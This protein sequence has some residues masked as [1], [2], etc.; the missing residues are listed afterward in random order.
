VRDYRN[1]VGHEFPGGTYTLPAYEAWLWADAVLADPDAGVAHPGMAYMVGLHGGGASIGDIMELFGADVDSG[2]LFGEVEFT[3][4]GVLRPGET[5][6]VSGGVVDVERKQ[7]RRVGVFDRATFEHRIDDAGG[8][9]VATVTHTWIFP[10]A[11]P[12]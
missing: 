3:F 9:R 1:L 7:G 6:A 10:R 12:A 4:A 5:Y 8:A 2:V 11:D